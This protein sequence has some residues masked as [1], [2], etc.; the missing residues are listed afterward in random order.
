MVIKIYRNSRTE[1][2]YKQISIQFREAIFN[3]EL[4]EGDSLP[5]IRALAR[6]LKISV[7]TVTKAYTELVEE[8]IIKSAK[9]KGYFVAS[10]NDEMMKE[11]RMRKIEKYLLRAIYSARILGLSKNEVIN[12][13]RKL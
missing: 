4:K 1:P 3:N 13:L 7:I 6:D 5:S 11:Q 10:R 8:G 12:I 9:G 2:V